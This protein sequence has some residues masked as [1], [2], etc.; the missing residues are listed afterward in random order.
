MSIKHDPITELLPKRMPKSVT[1]S[2]H[3]MHGCKIVSQFAGLAEP[4]S[5]QSIFGAGAAAP[6]VPGTV[7]ERFERH[8]AHVLVRGHLSFKRGSYF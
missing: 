8:T 7:N 3:P 1:Q 2:L 6:L 5:Q 4:G